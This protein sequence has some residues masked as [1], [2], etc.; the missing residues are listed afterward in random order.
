MLGVEVWH[1]DLNSGPRYFDVTLQN[2]FMTDGTPGAGS[3]S[4][5][6]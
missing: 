3:I 5:N 2:S 6:L 4:Y 1:F